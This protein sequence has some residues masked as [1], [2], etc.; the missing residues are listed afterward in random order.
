MLDD[1]RCSV[2]IDS[3]LRGGATFAEVFAEERDDVSVCYDQSLKNVASMRTAGVGIYLFNGNNSLYVYTNQL[4]E[5]ALLDLT[6]RACQILKC[7]GAD[8]GGKGF[9]HNKEIPDPCPVRVTPGEVGLREKIGLLRS[10]QGKA[11]AMTESLKGIELTYF[12]RDQHIKVVNSLGGYATDRRA[13]CRIRFIPRIVNE[14]GS[15][16][17][18]SEFCHAGGFEAFSDSAY[19][20]TMLGSIA[21]LEASLTAKKAP[22]GRKTVILE[23]GSC[24]GTF[25][26]EACGHQLETTALLKGGMFWDRRGEQIASAKVTLVDD[27]TMPGLYGSSCIDDE[28]HPRQKNTLIE[29]GILRGFLVDRRG[30]MLLGLE[31]TGSGRRQD[32]AHAPGARMSNTYLAAGNDDEDV[33]IS[34]T[35]DGLFVT[36]MGG[37]TGGDEFSLLASTAYEIKNGKIGQRVKGAMLTGRGDQTMLKIDRVGKKMVFEQGGGS[38]CGSDSGFIATTT[39]GPR[40]RISEMLVGGE[41]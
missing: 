20:E 35:E 23:G 6:A 40:M 34:D 13:N 7:K 32:Y 3:A 41:A 30:G 2:I 21:E 38:F 22:S 11:M 5:K 18:F 14:H 25:F 36:T 8:A 26:H 17:T 1:K 37:G 12:D 16:S 4:D 24:S 27:G 29:N 28:G 9:V 15:I 10:A 31:P 33:M 39:S 19:I